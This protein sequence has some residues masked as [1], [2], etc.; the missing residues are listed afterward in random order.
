M[1]TSR[2]APDISRASCLG[3]FR[4]RRTWLCIGLGSLLVGSLALPQ[5]AMCDSERWR[6]L[7]DEVAAGRVISLSQL[8]DGLERDWLGQVVEVELDESHGELIYEVEMLGP[9]GQMAKFTVRASDGSLREVRGINLGDMRRHADGTLSDGNVM[10]D[11]SV[12]DDDRVI[13]EGAGP[14]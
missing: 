13:D 2:K 9:Q 14:P 6:S 12:M 3:R 7:H 4:H 11:N 5:L 10:D 8:L 1:Q